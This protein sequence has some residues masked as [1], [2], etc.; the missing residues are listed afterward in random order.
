L[1]HS[2]G[3]I[4]DGRGLVFVG[5]S[6]AG[7][8]TTVNM[9]KGRAEILC[10][11][12]NI[13]RRWPDGWHAHGTWSHGDVPNVSPSS[14]PLR[15]ILFLEQSKQN[16]IVQLTDRMEIWRRFL[17]TLI[18]PMVTP[19]WWHKSFD[20]LEQLVRDVPCYIMHFDRSGAIVDRLA[21]L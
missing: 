2:A 8:S 7:K 13:L 12:R 15:A 18:K 1:L 17:A 21:R 4:L 11:D 5:P 6:S 14:A 19:E 3:V 10:D 9:L 16:T 20:I